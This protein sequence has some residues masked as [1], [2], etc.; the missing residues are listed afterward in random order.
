MLTERKMDTLMYSKLIS[1]DEVINA[2]K[3]WQF[4]WLCCVC[5][6]NVTVGPLGES[7]GASHSEC[8]T[9]AYHA[10]CK[11]AVWRHV[12]FNDSRRHG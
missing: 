6:R 11:N 3:M 7:C 10:L 1:S 8:V 5:H 9:G 4:R 12:S 2:A